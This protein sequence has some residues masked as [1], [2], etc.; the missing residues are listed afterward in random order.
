MKVQLSKM[1][2]QSS[3]VMDKTSLKN[4]VNIAKIVTEQ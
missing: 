2:L 3:L 1:K 4:K